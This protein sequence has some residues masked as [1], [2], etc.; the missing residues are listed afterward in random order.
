MCVCGQ[1]FKRAR[2]FTWISVS[3]FAGPPTQT[4]THTFTPIQRVSW[5]ELKPG[6][7]GWAPFV[8]LAPSVTILHVTS[9][10][11]KHPCTRKTKHCHLI[12]AQFVA[13]FKNTCYCVTSPFYL[14]LHHFVC[15]LCS[16]EL[17]D[18]KIFNMPSFQGKCSVQDALK[19]MVVCTHL[20]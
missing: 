7:A 6:P 17:Q 18:V 8:G 5:Q 9:R 15:A 19:F 2:L 13:L 3:V 10:H 16:T 1:R 12:W 20:V 4:R 14:F 11:L